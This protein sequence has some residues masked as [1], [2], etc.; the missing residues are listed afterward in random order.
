[1]SKLSLC[2]ACC[3]TSSAVRCQI[4]VFSEELIRLR[5]NGER[6]VGEALERHSL[7]VLDGRNESVCREIDLK[8]T[9]RFI[10]PRLSKAVIER[11]RPTIAMR[12]VAP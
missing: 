10:S 12:S 2:M 8:V 6:F 11:I 3:K 5:L 4:N 7:V 9:I 1:M